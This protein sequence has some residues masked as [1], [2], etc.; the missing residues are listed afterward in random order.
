MQ[1]T[2]TRYHKADAEYIDVDCEAQENQ[3]DQDRMI[4][5]QMIADS[6]GMEQNRGMPKLNYI[7]GK[8]YD[9]QTLTFKN[10]TARFE[11]QLIAWQLGKSFDN[12]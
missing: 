3:L 8:A 12:F 6:C 9:T 4:F 5:L 7:K 2:I 10:P 11:Q 1:T